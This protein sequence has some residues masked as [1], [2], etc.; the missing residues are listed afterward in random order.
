[1]TRSAKLA[2]DC[3]FRR[4]LKLGRK[5]ARRVVVAPRFGGTG[6]L[7]PLDGAKLRLRAG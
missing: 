1:M 3:S 2:A 7:A 4:T 6:A 5:R